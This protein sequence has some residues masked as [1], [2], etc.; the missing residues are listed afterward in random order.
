M[1]HPRLAHLA[2]LLP[3]L[4][5]C[6]GDDFGPT[7]TDSGPVP[8]GGPIPPDAGPPP[9][10]RVLGLE[11]TD[12]HGNPQMPDAMPRRPILRG[13]TSAP[14]DPLY[15]FLFAGDGDVML[16]EDLQR[17]PL[18]VANRNLIVPA[19]LETSTTGFTL[20]P[21]EPLAP[22]ADYV[23]GVARWSESDGEDLETAAVFRLRVADASG[24]SVT[25][26]WPPDGAVAVPTGLG[27]VALRFDDVV[28]G[29]ETIA[30][31]GPEGTV[32]APAELVPCV[33]L[34]WSSGTCVEVAPRRLRPSSSYRVVVPE[35]VRDRGGAPV[36]PWSASFETGAEDVGELRLLPMACAFDEAPVADVGC[37][38]TDEDSATLRMRADGPV[39]AWW[40]AEAARAMTVATR[41]EIELRLVGLGADQELMTEVRLAG[42]G[43]VTHGESLRVKTTPPLL[44]VTISEVRFD[45]EGP[46]P[47]QEYVELFHFGDAPIEL[48]GLSL[49]DDPDREGDVLEAPV[50]L[51][52]GERAL[53]VPEGF[54]PEHV[55]DPPVPGGVRLVRV[56]GS[57]ASGGLSNSGEP[58]FLRDA[59]G[60]RLSSTPATPSAGEGICLVRRGGARHAGPFEMAACTPGM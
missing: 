46:E 33:D 1:H 20:R 55:E 27:G 50:R 11:V 16:L 21:L 6:F 3:L 38:L 35:D 37:L 40:N 26:V 49:S 9:P 25:D 23:L 22:G 54:D 4:L 14:L 52:P 53:L 60:H 18:R 24:A 45:A 51:N 32:E 17:I 42:L 34:G 57:L 59:E 48:A 12:H 10:A 5:A 41:G 8:D 30:L 7:P 29:H 58:L 31:Q 39:R 47:R 19:E 15:A 36:G 28:F 44:P 43:P 2:L 13:T 56:D